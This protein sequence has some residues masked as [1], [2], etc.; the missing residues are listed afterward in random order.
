MADISAIDLI[1][2]ITL[3]LQGEEL[4][5]PERQVSDSEPSGNIV[6]QMELSQDGSMENNNTKSAP[7]A[8]R[9]SMVKSLP[10]TMSSEALSWQTCFTNVGSPSINTWGLDSV[11]LEC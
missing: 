11:I 9:A 5:T 6:D 1:S 7:M 8:V 10:Q 3:G 4:F 2:A